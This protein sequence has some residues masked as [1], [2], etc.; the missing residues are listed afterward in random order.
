MAVLMLLKIFAIFSSTREK[1][2]KKKKER[3]K[4]DI[5]YF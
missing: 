3:K 4:A 2:L 1:N 5:A